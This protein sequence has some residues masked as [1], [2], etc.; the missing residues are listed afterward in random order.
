MTSL[1][2]RLGRTH[3]LFRWDAGPRSGRRGKEPAMA[4]RLRARYAPYVFSGGTP[5]AV[6]QVSPKPLRRRVPSDVGLRFDGATLRLER[7][8]FLA[9]YEPS[10]GQGRLE[11]ADNP[12]S[13]D[14]FLRVFMSWLLPRSGGMLAHAASLAR[15]GAGY[16]FPA[17]SG[18]G[19]STL[20]RTAGPAEALSDE[21]SLVL[22]DKDGYALAGSPFWGELACRSRPVE[23]PLKGIYFLE[24]GPR[25]AVRPLPKTQAV[26]LLLKTLMS[27]D[28]DPL[29]A[30]SLLRGAET[31]LDRVPFHTL[32]FSKS[33]PFW[34]A[35][36]ARRAEAVPA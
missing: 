32:V 18:G 22:R 10:R 3:L 17:V 5:D 33:R 8:D 15:D 4:A 1:G 34:D 9:A 30:Q 11:T 13:F 14:S 27:F 36:E 21:L 26:R 23:V 28:A 24:K 31:L 35:V 12:Y 2:F 6:F 7:S 16:L 25:P 19:K 29:S 20:T